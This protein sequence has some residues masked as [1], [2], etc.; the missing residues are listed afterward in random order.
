[1]LESQKVNLKIVWNINTKNVKSAVSTIAWW[2]KVEE[3][4][5]FDEETTAAV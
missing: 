1:M 4:D 2:L 5:I 3:S